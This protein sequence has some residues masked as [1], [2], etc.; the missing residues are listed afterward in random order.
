MWGD[1]D[2][3]STLKCSAKFCGI[4]NGP[5]FAPD[6]TKSVEANIT[7]DSWVAYYE[8]IYGCV[9]TDNVGRASKLEKKAKLSFSSEEVEKGILGLSVNKSPGTD[10][11]PQDL[12]L[13]DVR[14]WVPVLTAFIN[15]VV[16]VGRPQS[17]AMSTIVLLFKKGKGVSLHAIGLFP[18]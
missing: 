11:V 14:V 1:L 2:D 9:P 4:I 13:S 8:E 15:A 5:F 10:G 17:W 3:S 16:V 7:E 6:L 18:F 12:H